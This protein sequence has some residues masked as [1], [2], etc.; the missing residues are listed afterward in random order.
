MAIKNINRFNNMNPIASSQL[1]L[2]CFAHNW[3]HMNR[4]HSLAIRM[5]LKNSSNR[6]KHVMHRLTKIFSPMSSNKNKYRITVKLQLSTMA[7][8]KISSTPKG[9][10]LFSCRIKPCNQRKTGTIQSKALSKERGRPVGLIP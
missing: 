7:D 4:I 9:T 10:V 8:G 2:C 3:I 1:F 6:S 5:L